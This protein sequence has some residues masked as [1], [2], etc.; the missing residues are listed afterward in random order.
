MLRPL[1]SVRTLLS[2]RLLLSSRQPHPLLA[3]TS[4]SRSCP[5]G[6]VNVLPKSIRRIGQQSPFIQPPNPQPQFPDYDGEEG[7]KKEKKKKGGIV[8][9]LIDNPAFGAAATTVIG[10]A[11]VFS[12]GI[13]YLAW[14]KVGICSCR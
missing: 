5:A 9:S 6:L 4:S 1:T 11:L 7:L 13:A 8:N 3:L 12:A 2:P 14:Y 10:L